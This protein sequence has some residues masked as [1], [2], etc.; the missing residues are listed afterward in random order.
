[1][2]F[3]SRK[4]LS[5]C[6]NP[7]LTFA[8]TLFDNIE[9]VKYLGLIFDSLRNWHSHIDT[10]TAKVSR[11]LSL[12]STI[13]KYLSDD[14]FR[15][16]HASLVQ[17]L[18]EYCDVIWTNADTVSLA[19]FLRLQMRGAHIILLKRFRDGRTEVL[20]KRLGWVSLT[21]RWNYRK[22][23][24][25][26][27]RLNGFCLSYLFNLLCLNLDVHSYSTRSWN[28]IHMSKISSVK[29]SFLQVKSGLHFFS[30]PPAKL[31][32]S[33]NETTKNSLTIIVLAFNLLLLN[34]N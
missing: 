11:W 14:T 6:S 8:G 19:R 21:D 9:T 4:R 22:Y 13:R 30:F 7:T 31:Y 28:N 12:L 16:L 27:K 5:R 25:V 26:L 23:L 29:S 10:V 2:L 24:T 1:M 15:Q 3:G 32:N 17:P 20:F 33:L 18:C 34:F